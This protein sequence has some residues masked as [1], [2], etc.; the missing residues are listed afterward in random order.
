MWLWWILGGAGAL[1]L[2]SQGQ[3]TVAPPSATP[4]PE[5]PPWLPQPC[6]PGYVKW[7]GGSVGT[8]VICMTEAEAIAKSQADFPWMSTP[9][10][11]LQPGEGL[12]WFRD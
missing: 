12:L 8:G 4:Y 1:W 7:T 3:R 2:L 5:T 6:P 11:G 10:S 9:G